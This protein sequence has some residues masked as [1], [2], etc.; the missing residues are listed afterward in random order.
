VGM[1]PLERCRG[2]QLVLTFTRVR[3]TDSSVNAYPASAVDP[4]YVPLE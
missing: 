4:I 3:A 1:H 2:N